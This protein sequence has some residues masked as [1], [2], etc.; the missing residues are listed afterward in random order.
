MSPDPELVPFG[1]AE[2]F[3]VDLA[4]FLMVSSYQGTVLS[5]TPLW[6]HEARSEA[7]RSKTG[8]FKNP[9]TFPKS[10]ACTNR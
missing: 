8:H 2:R 7:L 10:A 6:L 3:G 1:R 4:R 5:S 9:V